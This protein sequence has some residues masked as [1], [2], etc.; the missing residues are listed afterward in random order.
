MYKLMPRVDARG[1]LL[2][3][4]GDS[5]DKDLGGETEDSV[6]CAGDS[7]LVRAKADEYLAARPDGFDKQTLLR[8]GEG[9]AH[10]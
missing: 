8:E 2:G 4:E 3:V 7:G 9:R 1:L 10:G 5:A 6:A